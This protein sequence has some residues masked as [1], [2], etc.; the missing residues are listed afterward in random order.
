MGMADKKPDRS[1][2]GLGDQPKPATNYAKPIFCI[3]WF[4]RRDR[5]DVGGNTLGYRDFLT[6]P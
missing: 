3:S 4:L 2:H 6:V 1:Q 5:E